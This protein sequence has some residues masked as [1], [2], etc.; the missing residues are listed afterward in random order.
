MLN[1][2]EIRK[3]HF[4]QFMSLPAEK[5]LAWAISHGYEM[6][7]LLPK[8]I[9]LIIKQTRNEPKRSRIPTPKYHNIA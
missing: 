9:R 8:N 6:F 5:Q 3:N 2:D 4:K 7:S 1:P